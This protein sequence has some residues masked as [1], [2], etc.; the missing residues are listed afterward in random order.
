MSKMQTTCKHCGSDKVRLLNNDPI[1]IPKS[2]HQ[3]QTPKELY[4]WD[5]E[6]YATAICDNCGKTMQVTGTIIWDV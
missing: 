3:V 5:E 6:I 1:Y 4:Q 2:P